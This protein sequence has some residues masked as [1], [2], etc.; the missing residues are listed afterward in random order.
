MYY[1]RTSHNIGMCYPV[2]WH[3]AVPFLMNCR[4]PLRPSSQ[5]PV[6][7]STFSSQGQGQGRGRGRGRGQGRDKDED[8][9]EDKGDD[10]D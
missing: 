1:T 4:W 7:V 2:D 9:D 3:A 8:E 10:T 6:Q 5:P